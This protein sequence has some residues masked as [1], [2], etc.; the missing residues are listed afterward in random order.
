VIPLLAAYGGRVGLKIAAYLFFV[1]AYAFIVYYGLHPTKNFNSAWTNSFV[2]FQFFSAGILLSLY[3]K[4]KLPQLSL[5]VRFVMAIVA[6]CCW[7]VGCVSGLRY[8]C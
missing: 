2:Q 8:S 1:I 6:L 3:L 4:G 7:L 5:I